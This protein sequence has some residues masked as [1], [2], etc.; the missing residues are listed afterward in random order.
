MKKFLLVAVAA[1]AV[2]AC[3]KDDDK[4]PDNGG[5]N[6]GGTQTNTQA[7]SPYSLGDIT[8]P[9]TVVTLEEDNT[10]YGNDLTT[11]A[12]YTVSP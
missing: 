11:T 9:K 7:E 10:R 4:T 12:T 5:G 6:G 8:Y 3:K 2:V 1:L